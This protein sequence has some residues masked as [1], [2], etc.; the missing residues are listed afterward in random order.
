MMETGFNPATFDPSGPDVVTGRKP[1]EMLVVE[2][3]KY[4]VRFSGWADIFIRRPGQISSFGASF[5]E[6]A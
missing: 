5:K 3:V 2:K 6:M 4:I 1:I